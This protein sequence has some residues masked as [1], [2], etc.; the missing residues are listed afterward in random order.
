M[1][2]EDEESRNSNACSKERLYEIASD[3]K[4]DPC[5]DIRDR[6]KG[7]QEY[8]KCFVG[9]DAVTWL[10]RRLGLKSRDEAVQIGNLMVQ[11]KV[12]L[13]VASEPQ[14]LDSSTQFYRLHPG[15]SRVPSNEHLLKAQVRKMSKAERNDLLLAMT[16]PHAG[17][18]V[19]PKA[20][21]RLK[22]YKNCF[23]ASEAVTWLSNHLQVSREE[24]V[25]TG[26]LLVKCGSLMQVGHK[27]AFQDK[28][29]LY[30]FNFARNCC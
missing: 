23:Y 18:R 15:T 9:K 6:K 13:H 1:E 25:L 29:I 22:T 7:S 30:R 24:A 21:V 26:D 11:H 19:M 3:M 8:P 5:L 17:V 4:S 10:H 28:P 16:D 14:F 27:S 2:K 12:M 20:R